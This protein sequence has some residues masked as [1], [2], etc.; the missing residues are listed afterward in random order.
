MPT[1]SCCVGQSLASDAVW[2]SQCWDWGELG[3]ISKTLVLSLLK[4]WW[5]RLK[6][7]DIL[8]SHESQLRCFLLLLPLCSV[9]PLHRKSFN[10]PTISLQTLTEK[11][12]WDW[13]RMPNKG[14]ILQGFYWLSTTVTSWWLALSTPQYLMTKFKVVSANWKYIHAEIYV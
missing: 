2:E 13:G 4:K 10:L 6:F 11:R 9:F 8:Y 1:P 7:S 5:L 12:I 3:F 14:K